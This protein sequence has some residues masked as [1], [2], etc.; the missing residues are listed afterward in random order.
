[1]HSTLQSMDLQPILSSSLVLTASTH[2]GNL[3]PSLSSP[4]RQGFRL[5]LR[6]EHV[7][8]VADAESNSEKR[9]AACRHAR[10]SK[11]GIRS[12]R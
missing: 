9:R 2:L 3:L 10:R 6:L 8:V 7:H 4:P 12:N 5:P 1:M 11:E